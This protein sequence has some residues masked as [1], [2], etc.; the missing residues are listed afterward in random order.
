MAT[1]L[2]SPAQHL[3]EF[4]GVV[5]FERPPGQPRERFYEEICRIYPEY[6]KV[7]QDE[8]GNVI[9]MPPGG[10]ES[11]W[12][13]LQAARQL[14]SWVERTGRGEAFGASTTFKFPNGSLRQ[15]DAAWASNENVYSISYEQRLEHILIVPEFVIEIVSKSDRYEKLH[16]KMEWYIS[17]GVEL[18]WLIHPKRR[19]VKIYTSTQVSTVENVEKLRGT[20]PVKGFVL[21]LEPIWRGLRETPKK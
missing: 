15:A 4:E 20:G 14:G 17:N 9:L 7:E 21:N 19:E 16:K 13:D 18:G 8:E 3:Q 11:G 1:M 5:V 10:G 2:K 12:Q 6:K